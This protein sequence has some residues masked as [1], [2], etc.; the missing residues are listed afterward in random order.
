[1]PERALSPRIL[2]FTSHGLFWQCAGLKMNSQYGAY[3]DLDLDRGPCRNDEALLSLSRS[4]SP[5][6]AG[7]TWCPVEWF[8]FIEQY[9]R[10][11]FTRPTDRLI[12]LSSVAKAVQSTFGSEY[13][14]GLW[15][16]DV[17]RGLEWHGSSPVEHRMSNAPTWSWA[18]VSSGIPFAALGMNILPV[19]L[20]EILDVRLTPLPGANNTWGNLQEGRLKIKGTLAGTTLPISNTHEASHRVFWDET[21]SSKH[22]PD[23]APASSEQVYTVLPFGV[24]RFGTDLHEVEAMILSPIGTTK[25]NSPGVIESAAGE[26]R[27]IGWCVT[28]IFLL[29]Q[30]LCHDPPAQLEFLRRFVLCGIDTRD[31][32]VTLSLRDFWRDRGA[33]AAEID[34][35]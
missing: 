25:T 13:L 27:R 16:K 21:Q 24:G 9:S 19:K 2:H 20:V 18:S 34:I 7:T 30:Q 12:A 35:I 6:K 14:A 11:K 22:P 29:R 31:R 3:D 8:H 4:S 33:P 17:L 15:E 10:A 26:Y 32:E 5:P 28:S 1:M 23:T